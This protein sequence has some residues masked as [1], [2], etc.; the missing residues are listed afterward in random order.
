MQRRDLLNIG[1]PLLIHIGIKKPHP[2]SAIKI[3]EVV[4]K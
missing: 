2:D 1:G 4:V 3:Y